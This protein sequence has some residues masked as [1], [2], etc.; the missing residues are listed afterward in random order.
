MLDLSEKERK[1][2]VATQD[3]VPLE[4]NPFEK[5]ARD[6]GLST[7]EV[8]E[9]YKRLLDENKVRRFGAS[10]AHRKVGVSVNAMIV[11]DVPNEEVMEIGKKISSF[12][13]VSHCYE[14]P[15]KK[16]WNYNLFTMVHRKSK[17]ECEEIAQEISNEVGID[18]YEMLYSSE[19]FKK[20]GVK[21][22]KR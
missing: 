5:I 21:I 16:D 19:E 10:I 20:T 7:Q 17:E 8:I 4:K 13:E 12:E 14:R 18:E 22:P 3:G 1:L 9:T 6:L 15:R 2:L 11:W